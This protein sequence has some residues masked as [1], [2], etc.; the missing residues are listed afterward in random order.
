MSEINVEYDGGY[1]I[2]IPDPTEIDVEEISRWVDEGVIERT[3]KTDADFR[4]EFAPMLRAMAHDQLQR[5]TGSP[6]NW[7]WF[8]PPGAPSDVVAAVQY[9]DSD[10]P[11]DELL[12]QIFDGAEAVTGL[13]I[14]PFE[15]ERFGDGAAMSF[16]AL[17]D[18]DVLV[19]QSVLITGS[20]S[21]RI[22]MHTM[23]TNAAIVTLAND[24]AS[25]FLEGVEHPDA[26]Q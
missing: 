20:G 1:W 19:Y 11:D 8:L 18:Q 25:E 17:A 22:M 24:Q 7:F 14:D 5:R 23:G 3:R 21:D 6:G 13:R 10:L 12:Q 16:A 4:S 2:E 9:I 26:A 15:T